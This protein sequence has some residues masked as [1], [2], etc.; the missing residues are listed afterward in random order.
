M[1]ETVTI[2]EAARRCEVSRQ[3]FYKWMKL[4]FV[5]V[6][7]VSPRRGLRPIRRVPVSE[8]ARLK[9]GG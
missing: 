8:V 1:R 2:R 9:R 3:T 6:I 4:G 5:Q 7:E